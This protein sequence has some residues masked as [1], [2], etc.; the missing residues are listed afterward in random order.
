MN[1]FAL[2][3]PAFFCKAYAVVCSA[4][5]DGSAAFILQGEFLS[6]PQRDKFIAF[7]YE[8]FACFAV[9]KFGVGHDFASKSLRQKPA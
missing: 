8:I 2:F 7:A 9:S 6:V 4:E 5:I 3:K 1:I